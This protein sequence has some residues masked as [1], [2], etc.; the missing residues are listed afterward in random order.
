MIAAFTAALVGCGK[1]GSGYQDDPMAVDQETAQFANVPN[2]E[3]CLQQNQYRSQQNHW[4]QYEQYG[5]RPYSWD[6]QNNVYS[7]HHHRDP[8]INRGFCGC[9][10]GYRAAC[11]ANVG[12]V[13]MPIQPLQQNRYS[14]AWYGWANGFNQFAYWGY[15]YADNVPSY[16]HNQ[17]Q[18][19]CHQ[20]FGQTCN[21]NQPNSCARGMCRP[22]SYGSPIGICVQ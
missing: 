10:Q 11:D 4:R 13:C 19:A 9:P 12:M 17:T 15:S 18:Y 1:D 14:V 22:T 3:Q 20:Q 2:P 21:V 8:N 7:A 5:F 16:N 6:V